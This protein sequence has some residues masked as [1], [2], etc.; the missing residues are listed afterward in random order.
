M[1]EIITM[2]RLSDTME[3][4]TVVKWHKNVGDSIAEGDVLADIE[5]DKA[6]QE[7][8]SEYDGVLLYQG[9]EEGNPTKVDTVLAIIGQAGEDISALISGGAPFSRIS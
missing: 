8:E 9:M 4:G 3:E 7:F 1:A 6:I 2:P 5:T